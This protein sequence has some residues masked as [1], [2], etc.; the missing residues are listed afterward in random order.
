MP[1]PD[2]TIYN[3]HVSQSMEKG[4]SNSGSLASSNSY[5]QSSSSPG[6]S[7][8]KLPASKASSA[9]L[10]DPA[11]V[12]KR[13]ANTMAARRYRQKRVDQMNT[14]ESQLKD[15]QTERDAFKV[16]CARLEGEVE[17]LRAL[18]AARK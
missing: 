13:K 11:R 12:E 8:T 14:L 17:T 3:T 5:N 6:T 9:P 10:T 7:S 16:R 4:L 2:T 18:L 15:T 1:S